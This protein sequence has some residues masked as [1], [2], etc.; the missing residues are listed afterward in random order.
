MPWAAAIPALAGLAANVY[1]ADQ[2][3]NANGDAIAASKANADRM[4]YMGLP[5]Y[6][7]QARTNMW[8]LLN[9]EIA[10]FST[11]QY[12]Q[13]I[14][15][16]LKSEQYAELRR[17]FMEPYQ[18]GLASLDQSLENRGLN[19]GTI[20]EKAK[21]QY[22]QRGANTLAD[23]AVKLETDAATKNWAARNDMFKTLLGTNVDLFRQ[24]D[25]VRN[26]WMGQGAQAQQGAINAG[27]A[28]AGNYWS[29]LAGA[30]GN[31]AGSLAGA[32]GS[33]GESGVPGM[34]DPGPVAGVWPSTGSSSALSF[35][36]PYGYYQYPR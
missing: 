6:A 34:T 16:D 19:Y 20:G 25:Q 18:M 28:N 13:V 23:A 7:K 15:P 27:A 9:P 14:N 35:N 12:D 8:A 26:A 30:V 4:Y 17:A 29:S 10:K 21:A 31:F 32:F 22:A 24:G 33:T 11:G 2:A 5:K 1:S 36:S 3:A